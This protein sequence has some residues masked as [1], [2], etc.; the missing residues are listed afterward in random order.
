MRFD[1]CNDLRIRKKQSRAWVDTGGELQHPL[2]YLSQWRSEGQMKG[3]NR[4]KASSQADCLCAGK[5]E[6]PDC[7]GTD[8][9]YA[10]G[11]KGIS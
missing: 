7:Y 1:G 8:D 6:S 2:A 3:I 5:V 9:W 11:L 10:T 4:G